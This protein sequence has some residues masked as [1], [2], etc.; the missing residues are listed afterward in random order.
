MSALTVAG[1]VTQVIALTLT[2]REYDPAP[3]TRPG[4]TDNEW[5]TYLAQDSL[6]KIC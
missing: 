6:R 4:C 3:I 2:L 1:Y 5:S